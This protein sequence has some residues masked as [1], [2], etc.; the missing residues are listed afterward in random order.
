MFTKKLGVDYLVGYPLFKTQAITL[1]P[2]YVLPGHDEETG[3]FTHVHLNGWIVTGEIVEDYYHWVNNFEAFHPY[4][5]WVKGNFEDEIQCDT[6][7]GFLK[8]MEEF[9]PNEWDYYD[10]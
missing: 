2:E 4:Y 5:G 3:T 7:E 6:E 10:I 8:F 1:N 9:P